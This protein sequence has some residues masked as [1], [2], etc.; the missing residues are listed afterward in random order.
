MKYL[1]EIL[2][3]IGAL[4]WLPQLFVWVEEK[5]KRPKLNIINHR[6][7]EIGYTIYGPSINLNLA[8]SAENDDVF[9]ETV[10]IE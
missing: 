5:L 8:F 7:V 1:F 6:L 10:Y 2:A 9:I 4:A 3:V